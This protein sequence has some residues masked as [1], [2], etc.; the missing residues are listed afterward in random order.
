MTEQ[1]AAEYL[2]S[3]VDQVE[4]VIEYSRVFRPEAD[5]S[6]LYEERD[7]L[8][9]AISALEAVQNNQ[10]WGTC[11]NDESEIPQTIKVCGF[12]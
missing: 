5:L 11:A 6:G 8:L 4:C 3:C 1:E 9:T 10:K 12:C 7:A 2:R